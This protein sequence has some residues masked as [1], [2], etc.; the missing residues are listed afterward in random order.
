[1]LAESLRE[2]EPGDDS[3]SSEE[4]S[5]QKMLDQPMNECQTSGSGNMLQNFED[6]TAYAKRICLAPGAKD[7]FKTLNRHAHY[8]DNI[9]VVRRLHLYAGRAII[10]C[11]K[12]HE[13]SSEVQP[14]FVSLHTIALIGLPGG[15]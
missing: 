14:I 9:E 8:V 11:K 13:F 10:W 12:L 3:E 2:R 6:M 15:L 4:P 5:D 1:M 7:A